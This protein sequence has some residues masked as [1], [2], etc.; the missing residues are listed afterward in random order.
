MKYMFSFSLLSVIFISFFLFGCGS[1]RTQPTDSS[2]PSTS[3]GHGDH[4]HQGMN[5]Q[6]DMEKMNVALSKLS[7]ENAASAEKQ[8]VCPVSGK[9]LGV[10]GPPQKVDTNGQTA[11]ICCDGCKD[12]LLSDPDEY[13][14]KLKK[15]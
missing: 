1:D 13:L 7:T 10:M 2:S 6:T 9:M 12:K 11:W 5:G 8:H 14:A 4:S 15:E 3:D